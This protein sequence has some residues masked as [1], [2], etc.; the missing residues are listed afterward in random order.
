MRMHLP[1]HALGAKQAGIADWM[2]KIIEWARRPS[3]LPDLGS[4]HWL[5]GIGQHQHR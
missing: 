5:D 1:S 3:H 4:D 2:Q